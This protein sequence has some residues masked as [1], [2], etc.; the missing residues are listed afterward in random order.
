MNSVNLIPPSPV[1]SVEVAAEP[2]VTDGLTEERYSGTEGKG[3]TLNGSRERKTE[4][5][6]AGG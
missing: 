5:F 1:L 3:D 4:R 2:V 6:S